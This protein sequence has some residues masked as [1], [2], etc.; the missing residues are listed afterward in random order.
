[1]AG[2][3]DRAGTVA[4]AYEECIC[5]TWRVSTLLLR[6]R[7]E[8]RERIIEIIYVEGREEDCYAYHLIDLGDLAPSCQNQRTILTAAARRKCHVHNLK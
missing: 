3:E 5:Q 7:F 6:G 1:M 2:D 4:L 8:G